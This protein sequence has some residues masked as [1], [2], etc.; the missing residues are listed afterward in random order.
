MAINPNYTTTISM[1]DRSGEPT[2]WSFNTIDD[3]QDEGATE[4]TL[5][6]LITATNALIDGVLNRY[7]FTRT[8]RVSNAKSSAAG[9]RE[10]KFLVTYEDTVTLVPYTFELPCRK[11]ALIPPINTD[12]YDITAAPF[13]AWVAAFEAHAASPDGNPV[14]VTSIRLMGKNT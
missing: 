3:M 9:Q 14:N 8:H 4:A 7:N 2:S 12:E 6:T 13:A 1:H 11:S 5:V 10:E